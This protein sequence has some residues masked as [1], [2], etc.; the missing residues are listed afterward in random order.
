MK[1]TLS[2]LLWT[3]ATLLLSLWTVLGLILAGLGTETGTRH[4]LALLQRLLPELSINGVTGDWLNGVA[5][6]ELRYQDVGIDL[7]LRQIRTRLGGAALFAGQIRLHGLSAEALSITLVD[8]GEESDEPLLPLPR[9][10]MPLP[11]IASGVKLGTLQIASEGE[12]LLEL[13][14]IGSDLQWLGTRLRYADTHARMGEWQAQATG[15]LVMENAYP[16]ALNG[17][18]AG[19]A[20]PQALHINTDGDLQE[21]HLELWTAGEWSLRGSGRL[22]LLE[23][24]LPMTAA[25]SLTR[26]AVIEAGAE[27]LTL[28]SA[29][30]QVAGNLELLQGEVVAALEESRYGRSELRMPLHYQPGQLA[31]A[32]QL[33]MGEGRVDATCHLGLAAPYP[34]DCGGE[35][36]RL[37]LTP[38]LQ[39]LEGDLSTPLQVGVQL[40]GL[41]EVAVELPAFSGHLAGHALTGELALNS[42]DGQRWQLP[43]FS[44]GTPG[45]R[46]SGNGD[47]G[48]SDSRLVMSLEAM[49]LEELMPALSGRVSAQ[50]TVAGSLDEPSV[51]IRWRSSELGYEEIHTVTTSGEVELARLGREASAAHLAVSGLTLPGVPSLN[52]TLRADGSRDSHR[53]RLDLAQTEPANSGRLRCDGVLADDFA[54]WQLRC[55]VLDGE[56][57]LGRRALAWQ[58]DRPIAFDWR[59]EPGQLALQPFCLNADGAELCLD[60]PLRWRDAQLQALAAHAHRLPLRWADPWMP[61]RLR[62]NDDARLD[63]DVTLHSAAP[64]RLEAKLAGDGSSWRRGRTRTLTLEQL[65]ATL[66]ADEQRARLQA[67]VGAAELGSIRA[68]IEIAEP[69]SARKLGGELLVNA[70]QL[71][72]L[73]WLVEGADITSGRIDGRVTLGGSAAEPT[74]SGLLALRDG[75]VQAE[76]L[77]ENPLRNLQADLRFDQQWAALE[78]SFAL[79]NGAGSLRGESRWQGD[80]WQL[81]ASL[82]ASQLSFAPLPDSELVVSPRL[83]FSADPG[84]RRLTGTV[85]VDRANIHLEELPPETIAVSPDT[86]VLGREPARVPDQQLTMDLQLELGENFHFN[87]F[88]ADVDL[89]GA[90]RLRQSPA[91]LLRTSG[92]VRVTRG[93]YRAYGQR[94]IVSEGTLFFSGPYDNPEL[95]L[96]AIRE[97]KPTIDQVEVEVG[98]RVTGPLQNPQARLFSRPGMP[99]SDIAYYL[100][101]GS[102]PPEEGASG[103]FSAGGTLLSLGLMGGEDQAARLAQRFGIRDLQI[104][105]TETARGT[106]AEVGGYLTSKLYVRYGAGL[107]SQGNSV[108]FQYRLTPRLLVEAISGVDEALDLL[109][110]FTIE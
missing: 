109:Y 68:N 44:I 75:A 93:R 96:E 38:W 53:L 14:Q 76:L 41:R 33:Q 10:A 94:L 28:H 59:R 11:L 61:G 70:L 50:A 54:Q 51:Q 26:P 12:P 86:V 39:G 43:R 98:L 6:D 27:T 69:R 108:T 63:L 105:T 30:I 92:R 5:I 107:E 19:A 52:A 18:L 80:S 97:M 91:N 31:A 47:L 13:Q 9:V 73:D 89:G 23:P 25:I 101:T 74:V 34:L 15:T 88:G 77:G 67:T 65:S 4:S 7:Q 82:D 110:T 79:G 87:G 21:L 64:L 55:P 20:L 17:R 1:R 48:A 3:A 49:A 104:G 46:L 56:L 100:L 106:E 90:L 66:S 36:T 32:P 45:N 2:A 99:E 16:L 35:V 83:S 37:A 57:Q 29:A 103:G 72:A 81:Q 8:D 42:S 24:A 62:A 78:G 71:P 22:R 95:N 58:L 40:Q 102:P 85:T 60:K 84:Q